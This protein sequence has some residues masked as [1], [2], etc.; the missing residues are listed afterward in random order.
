MYGDVVPEVQLLAEAP[1]INEFVLIVQALTTPG[2]SFVKTIDVELP[3]QMVLVVG[4]LINVGRG[5]MVIV[6]G[7]WVVSVLSL[8][9]AVRQVPDRP[10]TFKYTLA[11]G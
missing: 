10:L 9:L 6:G 5:Y 1:L 7:P 3:E 11:P 8:M 4:G 2:L